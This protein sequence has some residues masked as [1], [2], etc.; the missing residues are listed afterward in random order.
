M[1]S[2]KTLNT[3]LAS[4]VAVTMAGG[5]SSADAAPGAGKEKSGRP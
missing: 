1:V 4:A 3:L 2:K 5:I